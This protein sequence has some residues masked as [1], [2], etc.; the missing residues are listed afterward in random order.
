MKPNT[1]QQIKYNRLKREDTLQSQKVNNTI[2]KVAIEKQLNTYKET[3]PHTPT[4]I[5]TTCYF[6][7]RL[8]ESLQANRDW[9]DIVKVKK[10]ETSSRILY[11]VS[12]FFRNKRQTL[13]IKI[14][15]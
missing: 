1:S 13:S 6:L 11:P 7:S 15:K 5:K 3:C 2:L 12:Q 8:G 14:K 4:P 9:D 10:G